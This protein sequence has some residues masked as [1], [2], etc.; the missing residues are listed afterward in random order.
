MSEKDGGGD[1]DRQRWKEGDM[2][3]TAIQSALLWKGNSKISS[4]GGV[5][6]EGS[7]AL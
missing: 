5:A 2:Y 3:Y 1:S 6:T 4:A 7:N